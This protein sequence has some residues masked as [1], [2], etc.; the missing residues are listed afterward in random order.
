M[1][2][3]TGAHA[4]S[5][6]KAQDNEGSLCQRHF[7]EYAACPGQGHFIHTYQGD[8]NPLPSFKGEP[9]QV[10]GPQDVKAFADTLWSSLHP[11][12]RVALCVK[13]IPLAGGN[14]VTYLYNRHSH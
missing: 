2:M 8:G 11:D 13:E 12:N 7:F 14:A 5:I 4:L 10:D 1:D 3:E 9:V 6:L